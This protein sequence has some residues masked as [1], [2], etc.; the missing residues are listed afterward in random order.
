[1][2]TFVFHACD[3][4]RLCL[5]VPPTRLQGAVAKVFR[6]LVHCQFHFR[7]AEREDVTMDSIRE[8]VRQVIGEV[9]SSRNRT[10]SHSSSSHSNST[11]TPFLFVS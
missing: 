10:S 5:A 1:M 7:A 9:H 11:G 2:C 8:R 3:T 6:K 4:A